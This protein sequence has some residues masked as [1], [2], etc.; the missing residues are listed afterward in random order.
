MNDFL[1]LAREGGWRNAYA[2]VFPALSRDVRGYR[3]PRRLAIFRM[4]HVLKRFTTESEA[5]E[6]V[7]ALPEAGEAE[8]V[9]RPAAPTP[10]AAEGSPPSLL[11]ISGFRGPK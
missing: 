1:W 8:P 11:A 6:L 5:R 2:E 7:T 10:R 3:A 9:A 4:F